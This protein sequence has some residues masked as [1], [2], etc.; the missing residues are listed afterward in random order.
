MI[1]K[2]MVVVWVDKEGYDLIYRRQATQG[3]RTIQQDANIQLI[4][5]QAQVMPDKDGQTLHVLAVI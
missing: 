3:Y 1:T 5:P 2:P 4:L